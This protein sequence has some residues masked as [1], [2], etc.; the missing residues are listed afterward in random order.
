MK[1]NLISS[2]LKN[3]L[4][5]FNRK[6]VKIKRSPPTTFVHEYP[7]LN[8]INSILNSKGILQIGAHRGMEASVYEWFNK[9]VIWI[10]ANPLIY[11]DLEDNICN[12][13]GQQAYNYLLGDQNKKNVN[14]YLSN[15]DYA[16]SSIFKFSD[17]VKEKK[18]WERL[19]MKGKIQLNMITLDEFVYTNKIDISKFNHWIIDAQGSELQI[20]K[21]SEKSLE[22]CKSLYVE[23]SLDK[24]YQGDSTTWKEL[25]EFLEKRNF[26]PISEPSSSHCDVLFN[27]KT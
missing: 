21:G 15:N 12:L 27:K 19:K 1:K 13:Y 8:L 16:S 17:K 7:D 22:K 11:K 6:L 9:K 26:Y 18:L 14:F 20:L 5:K 24:F 2:I 3:I 23:V 25:K 4:R 10:E